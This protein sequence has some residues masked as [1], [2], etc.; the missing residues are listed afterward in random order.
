MFG[1]ARVSDALQ[2]SRFSHDSFGP[3][4]TSCECFFRA[5]IGDT[6][7][8]GPRESL[9]A[10]A[11]TRR[12]LRMRGFAGGLSVFLPDWEGKVSAVAAGRGDS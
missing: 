5:W 4:R 10:H 8:Y 1:E 9:H 7:R 3:F 2:F 11:L 6:V 12:R